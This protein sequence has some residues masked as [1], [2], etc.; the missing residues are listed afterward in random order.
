MFFLFNSNLLPVRCGG[1]NQVSKLMRT[2][3]GLILHLDA[4]ART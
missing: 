2:N 3:I 1:L 4:F